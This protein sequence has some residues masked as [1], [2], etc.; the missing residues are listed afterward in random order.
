MA[1]RNLFST[2]EDHTIFIEE[3]GVLWL[4]GEASRGQLGLGDY[5]D[6][7]IDPEFHITLTLTLSMFG[8]RLDPE[9]HFFPGSSKPRGMRRPALDGVGGRAGVA[10]G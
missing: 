6:L 5:E 9:V 2:G 8:G 7:L 1:S 4:C 3:N 10:M